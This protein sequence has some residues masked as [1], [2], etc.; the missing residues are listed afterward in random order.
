[1]NQEERKGLLYVA[2]AAALFSTSPV[3]ITWANPMSP[4]V[5]T[6]G[7][8]L[9]GAIAVGLAARML[10]GSIRVHDTDEALATAHRRPALRFLLY[11]LIA[12]L[13]FLFAIASLSYTTPAHSLAI[14]YTA[15]IFVTLFS[16]IFL[17]EPIRR[18]QWT[19]VAVAILG[20][21]ILAGLE[22]TMSLQMLWG[23]LLALGSAIMFGFYSVAGRYERVR[24][25][26]LVYASRLYGAAALWLLPAA[27]LSLP[28]APPEAWGWRQVL[29]V[30]AL[31]LAPLALGHTLYNASL[32]RVHATYVNI[33]ASQEVT[34]GILLSW[35]LLGITP[36]LNSVIG[37]LV[38]LAG[39][40]LVLR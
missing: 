8:M 7:R 40:A 11:G 6:W 3:L 34:G 35:L 28:G 20:V 16:A 32:R 36:S 13:H 26:L 25:P 2:L 15:P 27:V 37:A 14:I 29:S 33:I 5:K 18:R 1:M 24:Y 22:P 12:A 39:T 10:A 38:T 30:V 21:A 19:G 9:V 17:K 23:D 31:G 4:F